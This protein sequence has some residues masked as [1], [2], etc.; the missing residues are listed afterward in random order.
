MI[1]VV[2]AS[3]HG[4]TREIA[5]VVAAELRVAEPAAAGDTAD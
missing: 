3:K 4:S 2:V 1:D 5:D